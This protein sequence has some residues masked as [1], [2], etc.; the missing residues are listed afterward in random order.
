MLNKSMNIIA[1]E[2][3]MDIID[4]KD[5]DHYLESELRRM[6]CSDFSTSIS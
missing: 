6:V 1:Q 2:I 3:G 5:L 4:E